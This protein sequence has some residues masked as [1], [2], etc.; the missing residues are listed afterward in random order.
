MAMGQKVDPDHSFC[1]GS[2]CM[3]WRWRPAGHQDQ[4]RAYVL[5]MPLVPEE[6]MTHGYCGMAR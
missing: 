2:E 3:A 1:L 6:Q 5:P 4:L